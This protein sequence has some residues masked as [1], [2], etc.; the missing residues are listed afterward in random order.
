M[1]G[2]SKF[3]FCRRVKSRQKKSSRKRLDFGD[4]KMVGVVLIVRKTSLK[5]K[6]SCELVKNGLCVAKLRKY[7]CFQRFL[8]QRKIFYSTERTFSA[9]QTQNA[10]KKDG[11]L[12]LL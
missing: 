2:K 8:K 6:K 9:K 1:R 4:Q 3:L 10:P 7:L 11:D 5:L 12:R